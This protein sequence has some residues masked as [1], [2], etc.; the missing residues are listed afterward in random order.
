MLLCI[1]TSKG[2]AVKASGIDLIDV[3]HAYES[4]IFCFPLT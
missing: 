3:M 1:I 4:S 2:Q